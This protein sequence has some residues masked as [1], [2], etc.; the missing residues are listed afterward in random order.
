MSPGVHL[1]MMALFGL[2]SWRA[3]E[4]K[5][6]LCGSMVVGGRGSGHFWHL[7]AWLKNLQWREPQSAEW[8]TNPPPCST[9]IHPFC[10]VSGTREPS[11]GI[12]SNSSGC[13]ALESVV[14]LFGIWPEGYESIC[15]WWLLVPSRPVPSSFPI[16]WKLIFSND[17]MRPRHKEGMAAIHPSTTLLPFNFP[18]LDSII[19]THQPP[20]PELVIAT[21]LRQSHHQIYLCPGKMLLKL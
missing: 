8:P 10:A 7:R 20:P 3:E 14:C 19:P 1:V 15:C 17:I 4:R 5:P 12:S 13:S 21:A 16:N 9:L 6:R 11:A 18:A 2:D